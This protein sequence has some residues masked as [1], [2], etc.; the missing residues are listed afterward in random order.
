MVESHA[1]DQVGGATGEADVLDANGHHVLPGLIDPHVH[2]G[3]LPPLG[4]R[5][6]AES[7]FALS[8][9]I[10]TIVRYFRRPESYI[11]TLPA[12][13]ALGAERHY[14]DFAHHLTLFNGDQVAR[15]TATSETS[16]SRPSRST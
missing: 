4:D 3:L 2:S 14:Q 13:V 11:D 9:G 8:G 10:T 5:L 1:I 12:Q 16:A 15:W 7:A 6:Q